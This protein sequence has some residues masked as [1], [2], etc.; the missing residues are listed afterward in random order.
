[1]G[2]PVRVV[3]VFH[4]KALQRRRAPKVGQTGSVDNEVSSRTGLFLVSDG[5]GLLIV[6]LGRPVGRHLTVLVGCLRSFDTDDNWPVT[7]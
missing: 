5:H 7:E 1:M 4:A 2:A 3:E 6:E